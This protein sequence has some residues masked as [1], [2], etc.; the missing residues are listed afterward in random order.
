VGV[1]GCMRDVQGDCRG[2]LIDLQV[3]GDVVL[4]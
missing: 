2:S 4:C 1:G 3:E